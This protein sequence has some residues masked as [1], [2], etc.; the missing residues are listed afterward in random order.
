MKE[1]D[2][3]DGAMVASELDE[4][5]DFS[6]SGTLELTL[7]PKTWTVPLSLET[8]YHRAVEENAKLNISAAFAPLL[9]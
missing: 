8:A 9:T 7:R 1:R 3:L 5:C 6:F 4:P 2:E